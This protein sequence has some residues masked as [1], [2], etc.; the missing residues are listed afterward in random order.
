[1]TLYAVVGNGEMP[2]KEVVQQLDDLWKKADAEDTDFWFVLE[3]KANPTE[4]DRRIVAWL[5]QFDLHYSLVT[6][7]G[8]TASEDYTG[9]SEFIDCDRPSDM[10][11]VMEM[12]R[13]KPEEN[14]GKEEDAVALALFC[15]IAADSPEDHELIVTLTATI[16]AGF[17]AYALNDAMEEIE[18]RTEEAVPLPEDAVK[19]KVEEPV[20]EAP[21]PE[22]DE[23]DDGPLPLDKVYLDGL[24]AAE[25]KELAKGMGITYTNKAEA[26]AAILASQDEPVGAVI[27]DKGITG[28][29]ISDEDE[30]LFVEVD[31]EVYP[32]EDIVLPDPSIAPIVD[33]PPLP[34]F[35]AETVTHAEVYDAS[36]PDE[37]AVESMTPLEKAETRSAGIVA[38]GYEVQFSYHAGRHGS[39]NSYRRN[40]K[41]LVVT[42]NIVRAC[43]MVLMKH[44]GENPEIHQIVK[45]SEGNVL[46]DS[47]V[48]P[49]S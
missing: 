2:E 35:G 46:I 34:D 21:A 4:T 44:E 29:P 48:L 19:P 27:V 18:L 39:P 14:D 5:N 8:V 23:A 31:G 47:G 16:G 33:A 30:A 43:A 22:V 11:E 9:V 10:A 12:L 3:G 32:T 13:A 36:S 40:G 25:V 6:P 7:A 45:R 38:T 26:I 42:D 41:Y 20:A 37:K 15:D 28:T 49:E 17:K 24:T 1:M